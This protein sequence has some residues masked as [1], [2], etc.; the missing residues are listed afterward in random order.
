MKKKFYFIDCVLTAPENHRLDFT[1]GNEIVEVYIQDLDGCQNTN[2][3]TF[4]ILQAGLSFGAIHLQLI[5]PK[6]KCINK[7]Y[8]FLVCIRILRG[9]ARRLIYTNDIL[10]AAP[11]D[12][13]TN[14]LF[15]PIYRVC[16]WD[17]YYSSITPNVDYLR[18]NNNFF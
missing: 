17:D 14:F 6:S 5:Y 16:Y 8:R 15:I 10:L 11:H 2:S 3:Y 18:L 1:K 9:T 7:A 13:Q 12:T 4:P